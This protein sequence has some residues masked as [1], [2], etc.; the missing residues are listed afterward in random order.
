MLTLFVY[1]VDTK[2]VIAEIAGRNNAD[3]EFLAGSFYGDTD[4]YGWAYNN[5]EL[6]YNLAVKELSLP[7]VGDTVHSHDGDR[8]WVVVET[9]YRRDN[10][11]V[12]LRNTE[13]KEVQW[14][15]A[16]MIDYDI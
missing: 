13:T 12:L 2:E 5:N 6:E 8:E 3:C 14:V 16:D 10:H 15:S 7:A 9:D 1:D 11:N 4:V